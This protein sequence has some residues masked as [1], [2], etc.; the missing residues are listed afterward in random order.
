MEPKEEGVGKEEITENFESGNTI[1]KDT[2][3]D[4]GFYGICRRQYRETS[5]TK[6][7]SILFGQ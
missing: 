7:R 3:V 5:F 6:K 2:R 4:H 1:T